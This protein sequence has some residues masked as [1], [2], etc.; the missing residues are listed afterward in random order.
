MVEKKFREVFEALHNDEEWEDSPEEKKFWEEF[1]RTYQ[2]NVKSGKMEKIQ[3][4]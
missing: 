2:L 1:E 4:S 3:K